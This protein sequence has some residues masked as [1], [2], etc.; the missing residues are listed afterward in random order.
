MEVKLSLCNVNVDI[1]YGLRSKDIYITHELKD[2][3]EELAMLLKKYD[4]DIKSSGQDEIKKIDS[5]AKEHFGF[6]L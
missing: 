5:I 3:L 1:K 6:I 2:M 4:A